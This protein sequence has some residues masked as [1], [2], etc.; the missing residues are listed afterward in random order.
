MES[1]N[2][3]GALV[4]GSLPATPSAL[5]AEL[6]RLGIAE[7]TMEHPPVFT[8]EEAKTLRGDLHGGH[9]KN[10]LL[11]NKKGRMWLVVCDEDQA[12]D[13]KHLADAL[14]GGRFSFA[15]RER[16]MQYLGVI[17]GSVTPFAVI[18]D[19]TGAVQVVLDQA[20]LDHHQL[21][22]HPLTNDMTTA[23]APEGLLR[24][25]TAMKHEPTLLADWGVV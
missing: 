11:R 1:E 22:F 8:V 12:V 3:D 14:G 23:I 21:N 20:L 5:L 7:T 13:L 4:D 17:P 19:K 16:L 25:L 9:V 18:N 6:A 15:S 10:L 2:A 24:F